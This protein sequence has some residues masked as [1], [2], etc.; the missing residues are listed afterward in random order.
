VNNRLVTSRFLL[1]HSIMPSIRGR[2]QADDSRSDFPGTREKLPTSTSTTN[3]AR[4]N[5]A[6]TQTTAHAAKDATSNL[7]YGSTAGSLTAPGVSVISR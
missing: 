7:T 5:G 6:A 1:V 3:K 4:R 2:L